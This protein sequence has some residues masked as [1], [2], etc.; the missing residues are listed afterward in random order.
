M[1]DC[2]SEADTGK[3]IFG[4]SGFMK[5]DFMKEYKFGPTESGR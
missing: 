2:F 5:G 3:R 4:S 1:K